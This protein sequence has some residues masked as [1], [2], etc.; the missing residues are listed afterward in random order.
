MKRD[1]NLRDR[2]SPLKIDSQSFKDAV[3]ILRS[4]SKREL[5]KTISAFQKDKGKKI[6]RKAKKFIRD[7][8]KRSL[9]DS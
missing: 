2:G 5:D 8:Q 4:M 6:S 7:L 3:V 9:K 1:I